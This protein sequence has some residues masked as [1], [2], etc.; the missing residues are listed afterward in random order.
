M[1]TLGPDASRAASGLS[2]IGKTRAAISGVGSA[3]AGAAKGLAVFN[4]AAD[5]LKKVGRAASALIG[6]FMGFEHTMSGIMAVGGESIAQFRGDMEKLALTIGKET[7]L[8]SVQAAGAMEELVKAGLTAQQ[9][10][11][12]AATGAV[13][14]AEAGGIDLPQAASIA[15]AAMNQ[16][17]LDASQIPHVAD[18]LAGAASS[19][20][21]DVSL[22]GSALQEVGPTA[23]TV[24]LS[25]DDTTTAIAAMAKMGITGGKAGSSLK[26][27]L[28]QMTQ[29]S[30]P[31]AD[32]MKQLGFSAFDA[33]G[34]LK[35]LPR[36]A[37]DLQSAIEGLNPQAQA[38][39]LSTMFGTFGLQAGTALF[40]QG[41]D[42]INELA[43][44]IGKISAADVAKERLNNLQ[45]AVTI[46]KGSAETLGV[47]F[48]SAFGP[49]LTSAV[50]AITSGVNALM[51]AAERLGEF[52]P[53]AWESASA[54]LQPV[55]DAVK[56]GLSSL[57]GGVL[58]VSSGIASGIGGLV[59]LHD[60]LAGMTGGVNL[61]ALL[62]ESGF[63]GLAPILDAIAPGLE[64]V[65]SGFARMRDAVTPLSVAFQALLAGDYQAFFS[66]LGAGLAGLVAGFVQTRI[67]VLTMLGGLVA[68]V[69]AKVPEL[70][71]A[72]VGWIAVQ[73]PVFVERLAALGTTVVTWLG[74]LGASL[75]AQ[76][77]SLIAAFTGWIVRTIPTLYIGLGMLLGAL[78]NWIITAVPMIVQTVYGW[79]D[80]FLGWVLQASQGL[81]AKMPALTAAVVPWIQ[82]QVPIL[83]TKVMGWGKAFLSWIASTAGNLGTG[84][85]TIVG[86]VV[87]FIVNNV[88]TLL[89]NIGQWALAI[90]GFAIKAIPAAIIALGQ[91]V[92]EIGSWILTTGVPMLINAAIGLA[93]GLVKGFLSALQGG[94]KGGGA[95]IGGAMAGSIDGAAA[96]TQSAWQ[97]FQ[98]DQAASAAAAGDAMEMGLIRDEQKLARAAGAMIGSAKGAIQAQAPELAATAGAAGAGAAD[99][100]AGGMGA[101]GAG[102]DAA[103]GGAGGAGGAAVDPAQQAMQQIQSVSSAITS[104][105]DLA[106][107]AFAFRGMPPPEIMDE[108][109]DGLK[110]IMER[111]MELAS[112]TD[113]LAAQLGQAVAQMLSGFVSALTGMV[114]LAEKLARFR[115]PTPDSL[116]ALLDLGVAI[117]GIITELTNV[118]GEGDLADSLE[119][120]T[121]A[122]KVA[123]ML[124]KWV[125]T[126]TG[127]AEMTTA[128]A[129]ARWDIDFGPV[130]GFMAG[131][132]VFA[133]ELQESLAAGRERFNLVI[134]DTGA[135]GQA[136]T[137]WVDMITS[138]AELSGDLV[139]IRW[140]ADLDA[141]LA[142]LDGIADFAFQMHD[143]IKMQLGPQVLIAMDDTKLLGE[144][145]SPWI[146]A[147]KG[148]GDAVQALTGARFGNVDMDAAGGFL[149][150]L[151]GM[152][153]RFSDTA[154]TQLGP[155]ILVALEDSR[156]I[157]D[158]LGAWLEP[159][160]KVAD[161]VTSI[162]VV[163]RMAQTR[164]DNT[165]TGLWD[166]VSQLAVMTARF[167]QTGNNRLQSQLLIALEDSREIAETLGTWLDPLTKIADV[168]LAF[169][170]VRN[171]AHTRWDNSLTAAWDLIS[172]IAVMTARFVTSGNQLLGAELVGLLTTSTEIAQSLSAWL[173]PLTKVGEAAESIDVVRRFAQTRWDS[174]FD[175]VASM[176]AGIGASS[177]KVVAQVQRDA[178]PKGQLE[179]SKMVAETFG[180]W[181]DIMAKLG[182][183]TDSIR[184]TIS[185]DDG[186][187]T[188]MVRMLATVGSA[189]NE[190]VQAVQRASNPTE[191]LKVSQQVAQTFDAWTST[192]ATIR[193]ATEALRDVRSVPEENL[194][195]ALGLMERIAA[196]TSTMVAAVMRHADPGP[197]LDAS[198]KVAETLG[199][200]LDVF[201]VTAD[202]THAMVGAEPVSPAEL[203]VVQRLI[204]SAYGILV[205]V[206]ADLRAMGDLAREDFMGGLMAYAEAAG[207][208]VDLVQSAAGMDLRDVVPIDEQARQIVKANMAAA[209]DTVKSLADD[210]LPELD[211]A[212]KRMLERLKAYIDIAGAASGLISSSASLGEDVF[213]AEMLR[214]AELAHVENALQQI[215]SSVERLAGWWAAGKTRLTEATTQMTSFA[216]AAGAAVGLVKPTVDAIQAL[217]SPDI[218]Q[219]S[220]IAL[221]R[222]QSAI[223]SIMGVV[224]ALS[225]GYLDAKGELDETRTGA[226]AG[227]SDSAGAA[228]GAVA[229]T[230][231]LLVDLHES[232]GKIGSLSGT[233]K[234]QIKAG[235]QSIVSMMQGLAADYGMADIEARRALQQTVDFS[236]SVSSV[237]DAVGSV[238]GSL[239]D[240]W[241]FAFDQNKDTGKV[242]P[243][244]RDFGE[245]MRESVSF[246]ISAIVD[247]MDRVMD[248]L[249]PEAL[250]QAS[251][252]A[253]RVAPV[254]DA[255][256]AMIEPIQKL[257]ENPFVDSKSRSNFGR[258]M[259]QTRIKHLADNV[260]KGIKLMAK[261]LIKALE[262]VKLPS[263]IDQNFQSLVTVV[264]G[265]MDVI[266]RSLTMPEIDFGKLEDL[267]KAS[268]ILGGI[269]MPSYAGAGA[270]AG[271]GSG[272]G[273]GLSRSPLLPPPMEMPQPSGPVVLSGPVTVVGPTFIDKVEAELNA[274]GKTLGK[275]QG[276]GAT[277]RAETREARGP[278]A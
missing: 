129:K 237:A 277:K 19:S 272:V 222:V 152:V 28:L 265:L 154:R 158:T 106:E 110:D 24:G 276:Q 42:G 32:M 207:A 49:M 127:M 163:R 90:G 169:D 182:A 105:I 98:M 165:M 140:P 54:R 5:G 247:V 71:T 236:G 229:D 112:G 40:Q 218:G 82:S 121:I 87:A 43:A 91:F 29:T 66:G 264:A 6:P 167:V 252:V 128:L 244:V 63:A 77:P 69:A 47:M 51:P 263:G 86:T 171:L 231:G 125:E 238:V 186:V 133:I 99:A 96:P 78:V 241:E 220:M 37:G 33:Q 124:G 56:S 245:H 23:N 102:A 79:A 214:A 255:I 253:T 233:V 198:Q 223:F 97:R 30:G 159:L 60:A 12:G 243:I 64:M 160:T 178:D 122:S 205:D 270:G 100:L 278:A 172:G 230:V 120:S 141:P 76:A 175:D 193:D 123:E 45:G 250:A 113:L 177:A 271:G 132:A 61:E 274:D 148:L 204:Q 95:E 183:A 38:Q 221:G 15:S 185:V 8:S 208:A 93:S 44:N 202:L 269:Q 85:G 136:L 200:W 226:I 48:G 75:L 53:A 3:I 46:L 184:R 161:V 50:Q 209:L 81:L 195:I 34:R 228:V 130:A 181:L 212:A 126:L 261:T 201:S 20:A 62:G 68:A 18:L 147:F 203:S 260:S 80:A 251:L 224:E 246:G 144:T 180:V 83:A 57:L 35:P 94:L 268:Q 25:I 206:S 153:S 52:L 197:V 2:G 131:I 225:R 31:A 4:L 234:A 166:F 188:D 73:G 240:V 41:A 179:I 149:M 36:L 58:S 157:A 227:F 21:T 92:A 111:G 27:A 258:K 262:G 266:D 235:I 67:G 146:D 11:G 14:L 249:G 187:L 70:I 176:L 259:A 232:Q 173:D 72:L 39:A 196:K 16:F 194:D 164:S 256:G 216:E 239:K 26:R 190:I 107:K 142:M 134:A 22:M 162:D 89:A 17:Q 114:D 118:L 145:I 115:I 191:Q 170:V 155:G 119:G 116:T 84:L 248:D 174:T 189:S 103:G 104:V 213:G 257:M 13:A 151:W 108:I 117:S 199:A 275:I 135:L 109:F 9:V 1:A 139:R 143:R 156:E 138:I 150:S 10:L 168:A 101:G 55:F 88:P 267:V 217:A 211:G 59:S 137:P 215:V 273:G 210:W 74:S 242:T 65:G 7:S 192:F 254:A 219:V